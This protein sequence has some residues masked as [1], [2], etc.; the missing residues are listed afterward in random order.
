MNIA[1]GAVKRPILTFIIFLTVVTLGMVSFSQLSIDLM[2]EVTYPTISVITTYENVGPEEMEEMITRPIEESLASV[3]GVQEMTSTSVEGRSQVRVSFTWGSDLDSAANDIRDRIDRIMGRLPEDITR[4]MIRKF[5][6]S[7]MPIVNLGVSSSMNP[8]DLR[9]FVE[10]EVIYRL[11]RVPGVAA[12]TARGGLLREIHVELHSDKVKALG[13][14]TDSILS[15]L[16]SE[17]SNIPAGLYQKGN[18]DVLVRTQGEF[19]SLDEI[20]NTVIAIKGG[21]PIR[22][23]DVADV[24]DSWQEVRSY[25]RID[26]QPGLRVSVN[27]QSGTNTVKV[28]KAI[29]EEVARINR[30]LP[31]IQITSTMDTSIYIQRSIANLGEA[32]IEGGILAIIILFLFLRNISTTAIVAIAIPISIIA[33]FGLMYF[34]G[35]TLNIMTLGG[36]SLGVGMLMD[37]S[38]VVLENIYRH[39][40]SGL[41]PVKAALTGTSEVWS[42]IMAG[43]LTHIVVFFPVVFMQGISGIMF[44]QMAYV[45]SFSMICSLVVA[46]TLVPMLSSKFVK[47]KAP[48]KIKNA[49][50]LQKV[51]AMSEQTFNRIEQ[52]YGRALRWALE[53]KKMVLISCGAMFLVSLFLV[54][55]VGVELMPQADES[56]VTV[57]LE[58]AVGTRP[59]VIN[60]VTTIAEDIISKNVPEKRVIVTRVGGSG[61]YGSSSGPQTADI[62][63]ETVPKSERKRSSEQIAADLRKQ[64]TGLPGVIVRTRA[65][66]GLFMMRMGS[67]TTDAVSVEVRGYDLKTA[68]EFA[69]TIDEAVRHVPGITDTRISRE[70]GSPEQIIRIDRQKA[71][72]LGLNVSRIGNALQTAVGGTQAS[73]YRE[74]GKE[75]TILVRLSEKDR[76]NLA[77]ILDLTVLN[78]RGEPV[79]LRNVVST[80]PREGPVR[81]ERK[82]QERIISINANFTGRDMGSVVADIWKQVRSI[83]WPKD[84][85][86]QFGGDYEEQQKAFKELMFAFLLALFLVYMVMAGQFESFRDPFIILFAVPMA[87]IGITLTMIASRTIFSMNAFIGCI[88]LAG[89]VTNNSILLV[90]YANILRR[91]D[92]MELMEAI[93]LSGSRRLRPILMTT[94]TTVLGLIPLALGLGEGG[95]AQAPM[96]RVVVGGLTSSTLITLFLVPVVYSIFEKRLSRD[97]KVEPES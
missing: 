33:T 35:F 95:E 51:Y 34:G 53:N 78:S 74:N 36:L 82:N 20:R 68:G 52:S 25:D 49:G 77:D 29:Q 84:F 17:N 22:V 19:Q 58:M 55:F 28:A 64:L 8:R 42:A 73:Y 41:S 44:K 54:R 75:Y 48:D 97:P 14:S 46:T 6:V 88:M 43:T 26:G 40:E 47:Y 65:G 69:K 61:G 5:D 39:R 60:K 21:A 50:G 93:C 2:P 80:T 4:P 10:D 18:L 67:S 87:L 59:D 81:I 15:S 3:Q 63:I 32:A 7:M 38:I 16:N 23:M 57:N 94:A 1:E 91:R 37:N 24:I 89:I 85:V 90:H 27:K 83:P 72:D 70:E 45:V 56:E 86:V 62:T 92:G 11:E 71:A 76:K 79:I 31:Q 30:D 13:L 9:Q 66:Q 96:A 12:A